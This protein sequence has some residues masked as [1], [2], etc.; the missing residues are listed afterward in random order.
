ME[1]LFEE[2]DVEMEVDLNKR[3]H[4]PPELVIKRYGDYNLVQNCINFCE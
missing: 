3:F 1:P 4:F 2:E